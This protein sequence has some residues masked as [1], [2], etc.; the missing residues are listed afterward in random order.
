METKRVLI[1]DEDYDGLAIKTALQLLAGLASEDE[2]IKDCILLIPVK[3]NIQHTT[4]SAVLGESASK[5]LSSG[6]SLKL[7]SCFLRLETARSFKRYA[8]GDAILV[9]YADQKM[10]D[11][12]DSNGNFKVI[13]SVPRMPEAVEEWERTWNPIVPGQQSAKIHLVRNKIVEAALESIT[14]RINLANRILNPRDEEAVKD[15]FRI[16]RAHNQ[17]EDPKNIRAWCMKNGWDSKGADEAMKH[18]TK[19]FNLKSKPSKR[20]AH[21]ASDIYEQWVNKTGK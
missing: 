6:K 12:V 17:A 13:V 16:L 19:A 9:V 5:A 20:G 18:A 1:P 15:A 8:K 10:M 11:S 21:W 2:G 7:G 4:L 3:A 14:S